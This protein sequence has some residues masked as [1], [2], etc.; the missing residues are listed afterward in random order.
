MSVS[1]GK[2]KQTAI[3]EGII[4]TFQTLDDMWS[5]AG[6][7][8]HSTAEVQA[9]CNYPQ[10]GNSCNRPI[11]DVVEYRQIVTIGVYFTQHF[12]VYVYCNC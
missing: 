6:M 7:E 4:Q 1:Q 2:T 11:L 9:Y 8:K 10:P 5:I 12:L 3:L